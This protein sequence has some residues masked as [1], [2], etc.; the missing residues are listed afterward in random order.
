MLVLHHLNNS[1][2]QRILW[3][4]EELGLPYRIQPWARDSATMLAPEGL[5]QIHPLGK[6]PLL[7]DED[8][9]GAV[10]AESGHIVE[11]LLDHYDRSGPG[12]HPLWR[13]APGTP[14]FDRYR[15]WLHYAEGS[16]MPPLLLGLVFGQV[17]K[18]PMP[19]FAR[20]IAKGI[21]AKVTQSFIG[22]QTRTHLQYVNDEL[23]GRE[24][25]A[26]DHPTGADV[27][28]SFP[29]EAAASRA[30]MTPY[31]AIRDYVARIHARPAWQRA[32]AAGGPYAYA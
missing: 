25:L 21:V 5:R 22:P 4:L 26:G 17:A 15:F 7:Q 28:M 9:G 29:L 10:I 13:P 23:A 2:S 12:G 11:Y 8:R 30:D 19:F 20:P 27:Q 32:L 18:A 16:L 31:P 14:D 3:L 6:S 1:R 24:W